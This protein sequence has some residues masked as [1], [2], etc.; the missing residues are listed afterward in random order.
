M[1]GEIPRRENAAHRGLAGRDI[2]IR[3][4]FGFC[5]PVG[6]KLYIHSMTVEEYF[7][8][9]D[10]ERAD[11]LQK[12]HSII[13]TEDKTVSAEV[14]MMMGKEMILYNCDTFKYGLASGKNYLSLHAMPIYCTPTIHNRY[15]AL[16]PKARFQKGCI[17]FQTAEDMPLQVVTA[18]MKDCAKVDL[19]AIRAAWKR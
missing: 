17:N 7:S 8:Q 11:L 14:G 15:K 3:F 16:L 13:I 1:I 2:K 6:L 19:K 9:Q 18:L 5:S 4:C 10:S 12:I